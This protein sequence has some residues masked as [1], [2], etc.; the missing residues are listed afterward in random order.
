MEEAL[1]WGI[2]IYLRLMGSVPEENPWG[3]DAFLGEYT[4]EECRA[5]LV[6]LDTP[7]ALIVH[8]SGSFA[9]VYIG[10]DGNLHRH[11]IFSYVTSLFRFHPP[12][13]ILGYPLL[14]RKDC[15][16]YRAMTMWK[17]CARR[18]GLCPDVRTL[19]S[20]FAW[21]NKLQLVQ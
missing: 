17:L 11:G 12:S 14:L 21:A 6:A 15:A 8:V 16:W 3:Y 9:P 1:M 20:K 18:L 5:E 13:S 19:I 4:M 2:L 10:K 7:H